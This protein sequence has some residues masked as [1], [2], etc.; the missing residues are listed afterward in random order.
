MRQRGTEEFFLTI[1][2]LV[3]AFMTTQAIAQGSLGDVAQNLLDP[4]VGMSRV[5]HAIC[6]IAGVGFL[7][8]GCI[9]F[10]AHRDN[11]TQ[12]RIT[13]PFMLWIL[14]GVFIAIPIVTM[15]SDAGVIIMEN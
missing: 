12:V 1:L 3:G 7:L 10:K 9:Q 15:M 2:L 14:G 5:M 13:T 11:P 4:F 6:Y 8:G